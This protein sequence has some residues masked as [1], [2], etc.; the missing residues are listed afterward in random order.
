MASWTQGYLN[1]GMKRIMVRL[2]SYNKQAADTRVIPT[3]SDF[4][5]SSYFTMPS[6]C[7]TQSRSYSKK[8]QKI[9]HPGISPKLEH[10]CISMQLKIISK[11]SW[12]LH[13]SILP[14]YF[15]A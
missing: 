3:N 6:S 2:R 4:K 11:K 14:D 5:S 9:P 7:V 10:S 12:D 15:E 1:A 13:N 8:Q